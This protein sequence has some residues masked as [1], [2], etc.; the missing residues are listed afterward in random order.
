MS[1]Q[2]R[3][4]WILLVILGYFLK[5]FQ[6]QTLAMALYCLVLLWEDFKNFKVARFDISTTYALLLFFITVSHFIVFSSLTLLSNTLV[7]YFTGKKYLIDQGIFI[8]NIGSVVIIE[9]MRLSIKNKPWNV[10]VCYENSLFRVLLLSFLF[11]SISFFFTQQLSSLGT[12]GTF[13]GHFVNGSLFLLSFM[14][15]YRKKGLIIIF[16]YS[17]FLSVYALVFSYLRMAILIPWIAFLAGDLVS[18]NSINAMSSYSKGVI[19]AGIII[20]P[21]LFTFLGQSRST[22]YGQEKLSQSLDLL[23][24]EYSGDELEL[25][26]GEEGDAVTIKGQTIFDRTSVISQLSNI[27]ELTEKKGFYGGQTLNYMA[28]VFIP[29]FLWPEKPLIKQGQWFALEIGKARKRK[30][31]DLANNSI[32]MTVPGEFYLNYGWAGVLIGCSIFGLFIGWTWNQTACST[33]ADF[34][35]KFY[36]IFLGFFS[37]GADLQIVPSLIAYMIIYKAYQLMMS[38]FFPSNVLKSV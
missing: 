23:S 29:R 20:F 13:L 32:N 16:M 19:F 24:S 21:V 38:V 2:A 6:V 37:L 7:N 25:G 10:D 30:D 3:H 17:L 1:L 15:H 26:G 11:F 5:D 28:Y 4:A 12:I 31:S 22:V 18:K 9:A 35:F 34:T 27:V 8:F 36:L 14:A 33:L